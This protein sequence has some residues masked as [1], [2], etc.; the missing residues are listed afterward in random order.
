MADKEIYSKFE[1]GDMLV[2]FIKDNRSGC[3]G[4][5]LLPKGYEERIELDGWW[6]VEP[7]V[8]C[9]FIGDNYPD[10]F[11]HGHSMKNGQS[12]GDMVFVGQRTEGRLNDHDVQEEPYKIITEYERRSVKISS[13][14]E[15]KAD[16][17]YIK[18]Y[19]VF[20]SASNEKQTLE[21]ASSFNICAFPAV[22]KGLRQKDL[23]LHRLKSKW[24]M[25]GKLESR[26]FLDMEMEPAWLR[27]GA[28][29]ERF[30]E[31]G[32]MPVRR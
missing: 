30:G 27:I 25:E 12:V 20:E 15:Y 11:I 28:T 1:L 31:V 2:V 19:S 16:D 29:S 6:S 8:Q 17:K 4:Y 3:V 32:S 9:K 24:S 13:V 5:T 22:G 14:I 23:V 10:G 18:T 21:M 26:G 7:A